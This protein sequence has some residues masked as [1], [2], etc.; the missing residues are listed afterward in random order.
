MDNSFFGKTM[1]NLRKHRDIKLAT[2][3]E[4]RNKLVSEPNYHTR[5]FFS[6]NLLAIEMKKNKSKNEYACIFRYVDIRY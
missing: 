3:N 5:K 2:A 6:E 1:E 4:K